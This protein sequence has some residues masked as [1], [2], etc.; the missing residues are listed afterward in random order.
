MVLTKL[1]ESIDLNFLFLQSENVEQFR[2]EEKEVGDAH[3]VYNFMGKLVTKKKFINFFLLND[4]FP[5]INFMRKKSSSPQHQH[6]RHAFI[7][8]MIACNRK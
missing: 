8:M 3:F 2:G 7:I 5:F 4:K 1:Y 6:Q